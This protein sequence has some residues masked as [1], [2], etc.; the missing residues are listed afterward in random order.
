[1]RILQINTDVNCGSTGRHAENVGKIL[2]NNNHESYIAYG[3]GNSLSTSNLI[4][5]GNFIDQ[6]FHIILS[7]IYDRHGLGSGYATTKLFTEIH[8]FDPDLIHLRNIHGYYLNYQVLFNQLQKIKKPVVWTF[9]DCWPFTGHCSHFE[10]VNCM[11]WKTECF[12]CPNKCGYPASWISDRSRKNYFLKKN[13]FTSIERLV[14]ITPSNWLKDHVLESFFADFP[15]EVINNVIDLNS[16]KPLDTNILRSRLQ[17]TG[18]KVILGVANIWNEKKGLNDFYKLNEI[19][20]DNYSIVLVGLSNSLLKSLPKGIIGINPTKNIDELAAMYSLADVFVN[21]TYSDNFPTTN[22]EALACGTPVITY[23]TG[24]SPE[25][26][27]NNTGLVVEK[28]NLNSLYKSISEVLENGKLFYSNKC[29]SRAEDLFDKND[30]YKEYLELYQ[31]M[32][33]K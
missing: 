6:G 8:Q 1:M 9:H 12:K 22:I 27:N 7:R 30:R 16:F 29:R 13:L 10:R 25:A 23:R 24:G 19:L 14:I 5:V 26:I 31:K 3:R 18:R 17:L 28:G 21:P 4:K 32:V 33:M 2:L 20:P 15:I 11:K